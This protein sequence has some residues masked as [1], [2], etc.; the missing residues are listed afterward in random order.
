MAE[1]IRLEAADDLIKRLSYEREAGKAVLE[2][3]WNALDADADWVDVRL[4]RNGAGG[5]ERVV[6]EDRGTGMPPQSTRTEFKRVGGSWKRHQRTTQ[7]GRPLH[8][9]AGQGRLRVFAL[10]DQARWTS[11]AKDTDGTLMRTVVDTRITDRARWEVDV[12]PAGDGVT[13]TG[14]LVEAW[15]R[16]DKWINRLDLAKTVTQIT[17]SLAPYLMTHPGIEV[18][19]DG[20]R[21][22]PHE[23]VAAD[24][25]YDLAFTFDEEDHTAQLRVIEWRSG[26]Q[27]SV[28]LCDGEGMPVEEHDFPGWHPDFAWS[29]YVRWE[30]M[31]EHRNETILA[32]LGGATPVAPLLTAARERLDT[33]FEDL[34]RR[35][36]RELVDRWHEEG[37]YPYDRPAASE[38]ERA[39]QTTFDVVATAISGQIP[40]DRSKKK[41]TLSL[42]QQALRH[43]PESLADVLNKVLSLREDEVASLHALLDRTSLSSIIRASSRVTSRLDFLAALEHLVF[44]EDTSHLVN[45]KDHLHK[46]LERELWVFG[47]EFNMMTSSEI[48]LTKVLRHHRQA[49]GLDTPA[50]GPVYTAEGRRARI[51]LMLSATTTEHDRTRHLVVELKA[52]D[53]VATD[54]E[55]GQVRKYA[56]AVAKEPRF[57]NVQTNWVFC[58]V[59]AELDDD[60]AEAANQRGRAKGLISDADQ[61]Y[62]QAQ[63]TIWVRTWSQIIDDARRRLSFFKESLQ[64]NPSLDHALEYLRDTHGDLLPP[65]VHAQLP[66][67]RQQPQLEAA[68]ET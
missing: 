43:S 50:D 34:R 18:V 57:A 59:V 19:F 64:H 13:R 12:L 3:I 68:H 40:R 58:L 4:T 53:V 41:L 63:V 20:K 32:D 60:V 45:E 37:V 6:V 36:R 38:A 25:P 9:K 49:V 28:A 29:A 22:D 39:E 11:T 27:R 35:R 26:T 10:G 23:H 24:T 30:P 51:D 65:R 62:D 8:G 21:I 54:V 48:G 7:H 1:E 55:M 61:P 33:H 15:G 31:P 47:E 66:P 52:P 42:L 16:Q 14:T 17:A 5:I 46:I 56:R 44:D 2:L 67:A